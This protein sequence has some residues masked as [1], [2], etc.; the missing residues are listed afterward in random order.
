MCEVSV[1]IPCFNSLEY[2]EDCLRSVIGQT[3]ASW[4]AIVVDD[5]SSDGDPASVISAVGD[6][7]VRLVRHEINR[8]LAAARNSGFAR[9]NA[10]WVLPVDSDDMLA[11]NCLAELTAAAALNPSADCVLCDLELFGMASEQWRYE[12]KPLEALTSHQWLPGAGVMIRR[13]LWAKVGGYCEAGELRVGNEDWDFW[14]AA[15]AQGFQVVHVTQLLYR[16]RRHHRSMAITLH[17]A[18]HRT[19]KFIYG[20][21][22]AFFRKYGGGPQFIAAGYWRAANAAVREGRPIVGL[23]RALGAVIRDRDVPQFRNVIKRIGGY[24]V[25]RR[26]QVHVRG[27]I[28]PN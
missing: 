13:R 6:S 20:R 4:E 25:R 3:M 15:A 14:I 8:G 18:D 11:P 7:R 19:R 28:A 27:N 5:C 16:Y 24:V 1:I 17:S 23:V 21:H 26:R 9:A 12:I 22:K 10:Q 2:L